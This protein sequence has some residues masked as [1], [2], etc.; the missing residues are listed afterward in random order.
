[1][2]LREGGCRKQPPP[3][4]GSTP[5]SVKRE[6]RA[7]FFSLSAVGPEGGAVYKR[8]RDRVSAFLFFSDL[9]LPSIT[10]EAYRADDGSPSVRIRASSFSGAHR[11][12]FYEGPLSAERVFLPA[13]RCSHCRDR[14]WAV[15][16]AC[17][18][19][20]FLGRVEVCDCGLLPSD[21]QALA[22]ARE[23][24]WRVRDDLT[25]LASPA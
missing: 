6:L 15:L 23:E 19:E 5:M 18:E 11:R 24:G 9:D 13:P 8:G 3:K 10:V 1:M 16:D 21:T 4:E 17:P 14:G 12:V 22:A 20:G 7:T 25:V 2:A